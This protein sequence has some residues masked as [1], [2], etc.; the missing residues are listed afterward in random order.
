MSEDSEP[1]RNLG[2]ASSQPM[3]EDPKQTKLGSYFIPAS[4]YGLGT[5]NLEAW[6]VMPYQ[7]I[8]MS[9]DPEHGR[10]LGVI[11]FRPIKIAKDFKCGRSRGVVSSH[12]IKTAE[13][14]KPGRS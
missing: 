11:S 3:A 9:E 12:P 14:P 13:D 4:Q 1:R 7:P 10:S 2:I 5:P 8:R 6:G